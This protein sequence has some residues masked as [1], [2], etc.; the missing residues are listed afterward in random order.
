ML[1]MV[2]CDWNGTL[3][4]DT[5]E[6]AFFFGLCRRAFFQAVRRG[7]CRKLARLAS[8]G[9]RCWVLYRR[10][11][12]DPDGVPRY[13]GRI[14]GLLND[15]VFAGLGR[16]ELEDY[17]R[18]Y[19]RRI[20]PRLDR[21]LLEPLA[22]IR[23]ERGVELGVVSSGCRIG[24]EAAL[25]EAQ[26]PFDFVIANEFRWDG[27]ATGGFDFAIAEGKHDVLAGLLAARGVDPADV[28]YVGDSPQD[29]A[30]FALV[31]L[32]VLSFFATDAHKERLSTGCGAFVPAGRG[33]FE[34]RLRLAATSSPHQA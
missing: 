11:R 29:E 12:K 3:F 1:R 24:I 13:V 14:V 17:A 5:L 28:M 32:P 7:R 15:D 6:E 16:R 2:I 18:R 25:A 27:D 4:R 31:G 21:R 19:A 9:A 10:A 26:A 8:L 22:A 33:D 20:Q 34:R 23:A 30:C